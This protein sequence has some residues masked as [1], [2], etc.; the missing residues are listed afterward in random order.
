MQK[1]K[2]ILIKLLKISGWS[3]A[4]LIL[5]FFILH[6]I[7]PLKIN[8]PYSTIV[9]AKDG[10]I[11]SAFLSK[12]DKW[13]M[14]TKNNEIND[15][16]KK[17]ILEKEDRYF[18]WHFGI[19]PI[20]IVRAG[21]NNITKGRRTSGASTISM[22]VVRLLHPRKRNLLSKVTE[23]FTATQLE[24]KYSKDEILQLYLNLL[25]YGGNIEGVKAAS[26]LY[27]G[28]NPKALSLAEATTLCIIPNK[29]TSLRIGGNTQ[30]ITEERNRW[31]E[32]F[33]EENI[34]SKTAIKDAIQEPLN[35]NRKPLQ[36]NARHLALRLK[37]IFPDSAVITS[38]IVYSNQLKAEAIVKN[39]V[40]KSKMFNI[41][42]AS[43][44]VINNLTGQVECYVGSNDFDDYENHGQVDGT[45]AVRSPGSTLKPLLYGTAFDLGICTN[46]TVINDVP[47]NFGGFEP[48]N[49]DEK[50]NGEVT[51]DQA[52]AFSLNIPAV[53]VLNDVSVPA[54]IQK[55]K[56]GGCKHVSKKG[57]GL[58]LILGGC[59]STLEELCGLYQAIGS[60][61]KWQPPVYIAHEKKPVS[62]ELISPE[63]S[64]MLTEILQ[65]IRRPDLP[66][67]FNNTYRI[68]KIAWK[69]GTSYGRKDAW[70]IGF[71]KHY[72][73]GV[74]IGNFDGEGV[75]NLS[76]AETATPLLFELFNTLDYNSD[77]SW[78]TAPKGIDYRYV[79]PRSG[80]LPNTYCTG[81]VTDSYIPG[82]TI[83]RIC[84]HLKEVTVSTDSTISYCKTC[85]PYTGT[86]T[87]LYPNYD[88]E[89]LSFFEKEHMIYRKIPPHNPQCTRIYNTNAPRIISLNDKSEYLIEENAGTELMLNAQVENTVEEV[90]WYVNNKLVGRT[91]PNRPVFFKPP[92][93]QVRITCI[94][95]RGRSSSI[96]IIVRKF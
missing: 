39:Y 28:K 23:M 30:K 3:F 81:T 47:S 10:Q 6:F 1:L 42:N 58:S 15:N 89:L 45:R 53:K 27:F 57:M 96:G 61:G 52:L 44:L 69:T 38:S 78:F 91:A 21:F 40:E 24:L 67:A 71:N 92:Y 86:I 55:L 5:L 16:L 33:R 26:L 11:L 82:K 29:P 72:T 75:P 37:N 68:P 14:F 35:I 17:A 62:I 8:V 2:K 4:S 95:D 51:V 70:S 80:L 48:E 94:D 36:Q 41:K 84:N 66:N 79:C 87:K 46:N 77:K 56:S 85:E 22:Q 63:A 93:G 31:L 73:I 60:R 90:L 65:K 34:F 19:N 50:F 83:S 54:F 12:D 43:I 49:Y 18:Y 32:Y 25:P 7:F 64:F 20:A 76:G 9:E 88:P 74:W 13:R 59:G